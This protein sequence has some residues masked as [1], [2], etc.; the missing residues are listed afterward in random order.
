MKPPWIVPGSPLFETTRTDRGNNSTK[1]HHKIYG[2][3]KWRRLS[4][5]HTKGFK[6]DH[7]GCYVLATT[8]DHIIPILHGGAEYD[9]RNW[10]RLCKKHHD[11]KSGREA[12]GKIE[13][14]IETDQG[15]I[16][17][18]RAGESQDIAGESYLTKL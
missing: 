13:A 12:H 4:A 2:T 1:E 8:T 10:Q 5:K 17:A 6:C 3:S 15:R 14:F 11:R 18:N 16:P 9:R 7:P